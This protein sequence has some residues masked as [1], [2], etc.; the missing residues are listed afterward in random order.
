MPDYRMYWKIGTRYPQIADVFPRSRFD[1]IK[2]NFHICDNSKIDYESESY[3]GL[4]KV[5]ELYGHVKS[6]CMKLDVP[7]HLSIGPSFFNF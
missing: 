5:R 6:N 1:A 2:S 4:F 7:E 3:D